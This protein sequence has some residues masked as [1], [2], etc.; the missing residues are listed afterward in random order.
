ML[1]T[2]LALLSSVKLFLKTNVYAFI[3]IFTNYFRIILK[4]LTKSNILNTLVLKKYEKFAN[5]NLED[6]PWPRGF[7][8]LAWRRFVLKKS[9]LGLDRCVLD[10][11]SAIYDVY[12]S[13][14]EKRFSTSQI[15]SKRLF[16][17]FS[18]PC[19]SP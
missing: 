4:N 1:T 16:W 18:Q 10:S 8:S 2:A 13:A 15:G 9:V 12:Q 7:L 5:N 6:G 11:T 3:D 19:L 14:L 17:F